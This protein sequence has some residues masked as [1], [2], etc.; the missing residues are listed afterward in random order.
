MYT[1]SL[2]IFIQPPKDDS[3][4]LDI[5]HCSLSNIEQLLRLIH[6]VDDYVSLER[7]NLFLTLEFH[8]MY[9]NHK[10]HTYCIITINNMYLIQFTYDATIITM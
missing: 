9:G 10:K 3:L 5:D 1:T 6:F 7:Q 2:L 4:I 8:V